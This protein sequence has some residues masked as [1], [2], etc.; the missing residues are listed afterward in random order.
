MSY[1]IL[2]CDEDGVSIDG[3]LTEAE[4]LKKITPD[5]DGCAYYGADLK[6]LKKVPG[7]D[8][9]DWRAPDGSLLIIKGKIVAPKVVQTATKMELP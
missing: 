9:G 2:K 8:K 7:Q 1:F 5:E 3:P 4:V 6:F